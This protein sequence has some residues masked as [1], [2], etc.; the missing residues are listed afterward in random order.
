MKKLFY[1]GKELY[2]LAVTFAA[3]G[4]WDFIAGMMYIFAIGTGRAIDQPPLHPFYAIFTGSFFLCFAYIQILSSFNI[5]RY[6]FNVGCLVIGRIFYVAV[7]FG[8]M[9][10]DHEFPGTFWFTGIID[11]IFAV[12]Y[13]VFAAKAGIK[14]AELFLPAIKNNL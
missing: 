13:L 9:V 2:P 1:K 14:P 12:L 11:S 4:I 6:L 5:R 10:L 8:Y 7:L 3:S